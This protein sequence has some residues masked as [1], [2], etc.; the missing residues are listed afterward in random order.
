[1]LPRIHNSRQRGPHMASYPKR[2]QVRSPEPGARGVTP[3]VRSKSRDRLASLLTHSRKPAR[4]QERCEVALVGNYPARSDDSWMSRGQLGESF[5]ITSP[6][7]PSSFASI[8]LFPSQL[9][10]SSRIHHSDLTTTIAQGSFP[11][12]PSA[13]FVDTS[14]RGF[15]HL[16]SSGSPADIPRSA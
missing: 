10:S 8:S 15:R 1:M 13:G 3:S 16:A 6:P 5:L 12:L 11:S 7:S 14:S 2:H 4:R 9:T